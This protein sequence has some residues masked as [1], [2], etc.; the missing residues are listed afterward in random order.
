MSLPSGHIMTLPH[1]PVSIVCLSTI[2][3]EEMCPIKPPQNDAIPLCDVTDT[4]QGTA[5]ADMNPPPHVH[6]DT[7]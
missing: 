4:D 7:E 1:I 3:S 6:L 5:M 2:C